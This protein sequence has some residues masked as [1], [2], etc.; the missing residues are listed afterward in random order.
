MFG[1]KK[2]KPEKREIVQELT[3][4]EIDGLKNQVADLTNTIDTLPEVEKPKRYEELGAVYV[5]LGQT[6]DAIDAYETS[7]KLKEQFG[8]AYNAL[9]NLYEIKRKE[10]AMAR[11][12]SEIQKWVTKT[13]TLLDMSKRVLRSNMF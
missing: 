10:A 5:K 6:D 9:L 12:D 4:E 13:D 1:F 3:P 11:D 8:D 7:L 2:K